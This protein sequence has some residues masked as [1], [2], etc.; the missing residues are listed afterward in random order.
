MFVLDVL[1]EGPLIPSISLDGCGGAYRPAPAELQTLK[2]HLLQS[3][4][5]FVAMSRLCPGEVFLECRQASVRLE[6]SSGNQ[7]LITLQDPVDRAGAKEIGAV[8][9]RH[10][11]VL[12]PI[13]HR[14]HEISFGGPVFNLE[15]LEAQISQF[16]TS[17]MRP[18]SVAQ[19]KPEKE[20]SG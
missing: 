8:I 3:L 7:L 5:F 2:I 9:Q 11:E 16:A 13:L 4:I 12:V 19:T 17:S 15:L 1:D 18:R 14:K 6:N 10:L 20:V